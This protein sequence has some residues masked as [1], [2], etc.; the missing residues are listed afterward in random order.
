LS[1]Y[2]SCKKGS[3]S[4]KQGDMMPNLQ[5]QGIS[6]LT[7]LLIDKLVLGR[8]TLAEVA[9]VTGLSEQWLQSQYGSVKEYSP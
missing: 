5:T 6:P 3:D 4:N 7:K 8:F 2:K 9:K 1:K